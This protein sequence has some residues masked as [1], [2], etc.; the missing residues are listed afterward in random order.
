M[1]AETHIATTG[2]CRRRRRPRTSEDASGRGDARGALPAPLSAL[3]RRRRD[4]G[5]RK[6]HRAL[7]EPG[8]HARLPSAGRARALL[9][10][11]RPRAKAR[12][13]ARDD[14]RGSGAGSVC[15]PVAPTTW[16]PPPLSAGLPRGLAGYSAVRREVA[17]AHAGERARLDFLLGGSA[18]PAG[19]ARG[20]ERH[21]RRGRLARFPDSVTPARP[22]PPVAALRRCARAARA[23]RCSSWC[24]APTATRS[25]PPTTSIPP[26]ARRCAPRQ[27]AGVEL[28]ALGARVDGARHPLRAR[29]AGAAAVSEAGPARQDAGALRAQLLAW[30]R[31][32]RRDLPWRRTRDPV[33]DLDLRGDAPAD[34]RRDGDPLLRALPGALPRRRRRSPAPSSTTCSALW[35]GLGYYSR[36]RNLHR[37]AQQVVER[38]GGAL[39]DDAD[40]LRALPGIGRYTA[41]AIASIAFDRPEPIVDG[42]VRARARAAARDPRRRRRAP[43]AARRLW[44]EAAALARGP[45]PGRAQPGADG[46]RRHACARRAR[47]AAPPARSRALCRARGGGRRGGAARARRAGAR[48]ARCEAVGGAAAA[49]AAAR[50]RCAGRRAGCSAGSGSCPGGD[51][52]RRRAARGGRWPRLAERVGLRVDGAAPARRRRARVHATGACALA[53]FRLRGPRARAPAR[54]FAAHRW[55]VAGAPSRRCRHGALDAQGAGRL[56]LHDAPAGCDTRRP[57]RRRFRP[58]RWPTP[59]R[60]QTRREPIPIGTRSRAPAACADRGWRTGAR[61]ATAPARDERARAIERAG[62]GPRLLAQ[63]PPRR[64]HAPGG[65]RPARPGA[66]AAPRAWSRRSWSSRT[67]AGCAACAS[68]TGAAPLA[69]RRGGAEAEPAALA[70]ARPPR[71]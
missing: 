59:T 9:A 20:E 40:A 41:G 55:L 61:P 23:P 44:E 12:L 22:P 63:L 18:A 62:L 51:L 33:R 24:S 57:A 69:E 37:A 43:A 67:R 50:S 25:S 5:G 10:Q 39:P 7:P 29:A 19:L 60:A 30:Y 13:Y 70:R 31:A 65:P 52:G 1:G 11:R 3:L 8:Q 49:R 53:L 45:E 26:T 68:C 35:A 47:R 54:G 15:T 4:G 38:H 56:A 34:A 64:V 6:A 27:R 14:A 17:V 2:G 66:A 36:A 48:R 71:A 58:R 28:L 32:H 42:N 16:W 46:A 21:P